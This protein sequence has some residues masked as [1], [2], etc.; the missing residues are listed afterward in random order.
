MKDGMF[1]SA[2]SQF[3]VDWFKVA[4]PTF[5]YNNL[6]LTISTATTGATIYYTT[7]GSNPLEDLSRAVRYTNPIQL[8]ADA[9]IKAAAIKTDFN[10]SEIATYSFVKADYVCKQPQITRDGS[11][12]RLMMSC[13]VADA[14]IY[15]TTDGSTPTTSS[16][17]YTGPVMVAY[18]CTV[19]AIATRSDLFP[20]DVSEFTVDWLTAS[21]VMVFVML[22]ALSS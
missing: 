12:D 14:V 7:N 5:S 19:R 2:Q 1:N 6:Q 17:R 13:E 20:S 9:T 15:Y 16:T 11:S 21:A 8:D 10:D 3:T 4:T 22:L 18:N